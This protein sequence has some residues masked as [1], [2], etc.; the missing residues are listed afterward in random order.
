MRIEK[1]EQIST[2]ISQ[3]SLKVRVAEEIKSLLANNKT[4]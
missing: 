4:I 2:T 1:R 3:V